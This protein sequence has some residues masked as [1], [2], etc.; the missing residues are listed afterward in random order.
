MS[1]TK[2]ILIVEERIVERHTCLVTFIMHILPTHLESSI[3]YYLVFRQNYPYF[4]FYC[5]F[6]DKIN[7]NLTGESY[8]IPPFP[9]TTL[10]A[11]MMMFG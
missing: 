1:R 10:C 6:I 5:I 2:T 8:V 9:L 4:G 7:V 3:G 11:S